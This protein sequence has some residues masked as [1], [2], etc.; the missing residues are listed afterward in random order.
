MEEQLKKILPEPG[1]IARFFKT[2]PQEVKRIYS[3][4]PK[5]ARIWLGFLS[6]AIVIW[7]FL[8][9]GDF[10]FLLTFASM[11]RCFGF[12]LLNYKVWTGMSARGVSVKTLELYAAAFFAR[13]LS[14]MRHQGYLPFDK[15]GDWLYHLIEFVSL[16]AVGLLLF[17]IFG[18]LKST[19]E[20]K[21]DKFGNL[22]IPPEYGAVYLFVPCVII[23][24]IFHPELNKE[25]FSDTC[26]TISMYIEAVA[27]LPQLYMFQKQAD[28]QDGTVEAMLS[29]TT[30]ALG[31]SRAFELFFWLGSFHELSNSSGKLPG[32]IILLS[33]FGHMI[34]MADFFYYYLKA[35]SKGG[36]MELPTYS[37]MNV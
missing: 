29:H 16:G 13:L 12:S 2:L 31:F 11:W 34:V 4:D 25:F 22:Q 9:S 19:Y 5:S 24:V 20:A 30:F 14:I 15:T 35:V 10:S 18:P 32:Y 17:G 6:T 3:N 33:Q 7:I 23:A 26:W 27:M 36:P 28:D 8:S 21:Y 1:T 37:S